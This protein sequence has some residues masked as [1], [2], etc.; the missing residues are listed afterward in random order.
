MRKSVSELENILRSQDGLVYALTY[1]E[2]EFLQSLAVAINNIKNDPKSK[3]KTSMQ[4]FVY[5]RP[6]GLYK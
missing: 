4:I 2:N 6:Q 1:E 5:S 3:M